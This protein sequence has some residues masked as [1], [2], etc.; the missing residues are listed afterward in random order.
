MFVSLIK[1]LRKCLSFHDLM[2]QEN[3]YK[4]SLLTKP[5]ARDQGKKT[6][7]CQSKLCAVQIR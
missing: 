2:S 5:E 7:C 4:N 1:Y 3:A 6:T